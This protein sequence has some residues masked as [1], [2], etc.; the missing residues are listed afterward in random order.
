MSNCTL[1]LGEDKWRDLKA[2]IDDLKAKRKDQPLSRMHYGDVSFLLGYAAAG[3]KF[4]WL[5]LS[6]DGRQASFYLPCLRLFIVTIVSKICSNTVLK[7]W[8]RFL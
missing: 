8:L 3:T 4:Q 6:A 2:A 1:L 7:K 5:W